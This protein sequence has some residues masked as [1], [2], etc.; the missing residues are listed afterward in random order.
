MST[1]YFLGISLGGGLL[2]LFLA[3]GWGSYKEK[4]IPEKGIL[5]RWFVAGLVACG[6]AAY[7]WIFGSGGNV[8][9]IITKIGGALDLESFLKLASIGGAAAAATSAEETVE[10]LQ[11]SSNMV[12]VE[13]KKPEL[14]VGMPNF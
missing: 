11:E 4:K 12:T 13:E 10:T 7:V 6:L 1:L 14:K 3:A 5:F 2:A 9:E 8:G